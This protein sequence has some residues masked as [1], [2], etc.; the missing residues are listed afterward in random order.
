MEVRD[1]PHPGNTTGGQKSGKVRLDGPIPRLE[2]KAPQTETLRASGAEVAM[3]DERYVSQFDWEAVFGD[4]SLNAIITSTF[5][6]EELE[7]WFLDREL[8]LAQEK[9]PAA[10]IPCDCPV[11]ED[12]EV[13]KRVD[14][15]ETYVDNLER[16]VPQLRSF[17]VETIPLVK[18]ETEFERS[19]C[20]EAFEDLGISRIS[21]YGAQYFTYGYRWK[22]L[23][24][25]IQNITVEFDPDDLLIIGLQAASHLRQLPPCVSGAAGQ[26]WMSQAEV[27]TEPPAVAARQY[28]SWAST[29]SETL[30]GGQTCLGSFARNRGWS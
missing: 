23:R 24:A 1:S 7:Y 15:I 25:R 18:G 26:R 19:L 12:D 9:Q 10:I 17:G 20:Y 28:D 22:D 6:D 2:P 4:R 14:T 5:N 8:D 11:Y 16:I 21:F 27:G 29:I 13:V 3:V 30:H